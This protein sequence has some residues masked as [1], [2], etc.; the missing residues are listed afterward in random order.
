MAEG[1][2]WIS[3]FF[4]DTSYVRGF[5]V[6]WDAPGWREISKK[7][8][9]PPETLP[10][11]VY[12]E[13]R[14]DT[15]QDLPPVFQGGGGVNVCPALADV[16]RRFNLV[17]G[18]D[19][20]GGVFPIQLYL[21]DR[22]TPVRTDYSVLVYGGK[23][24]GGLIPEESRGLRAGKYA[25]IPPAH[26]TLS[27]IKDGDIAVRATVRSGSD[28]WFDPKLLS[29]VFMSDRLV[30]ALQDAGFAQH[31]KPIRCRVVEYH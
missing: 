18:G 22:K 28:L 20:K 6:D 27:E 24:E 12:A 13:Y 4:T 30:Q 26:W 31:F 7:R 17:E 23:K 5:E 16:F 29:E 10:L 15:L 3:K 1:D 2:V 8:S 21:H 9:P 19:G 25:S 11:P 14:D